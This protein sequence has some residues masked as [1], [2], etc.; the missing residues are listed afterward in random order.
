MIPLERNEVFL[1]LYLPPLTWGVAPAISEEELK[2]ELTLNLTKEDL[3]ACNSLFLMQDIENTRALWLGN[4]LAPMGQFELDSLKTSLVDYDGLPPFFAN[5]LDTYQTNEERAANFSQL[6]LGYY[7]Y[8]KSSPYP[9]IRWWGNFAEKGRFAFQFLRSKEVGAEEIDERFHPL[10]GFFADPHLKAADL[11]EAINHF[12]FDRVGES[13]DEDPFAI[14][15][16][17]AYIVQFYLI[18]LSLEVTE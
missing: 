3:K 10:E 5:F 9:F 7:Q 13:L 2:E 17:F 15:K 1:L 16:V 14:D 12:L 8:L 6:L 4:E 11:A 18:H